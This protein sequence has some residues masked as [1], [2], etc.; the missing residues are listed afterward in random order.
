MVTLWV[1][2]LVM[3]RVRKYKKIKAVDP[4]SKRK[5]ARDESKYDLPPDELKSE[6]QVNLT[7]RH[8]MEIWESRK[9]EEEQGTV[10]G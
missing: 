7:T 1:L 5:V 6:F 9:E 10:L 3:G 4:F 8:V 2:Y